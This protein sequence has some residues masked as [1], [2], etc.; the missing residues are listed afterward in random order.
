MMYESNEPTI[1]QIKLVVLNE[2]STVDIT[3]QKELPI[4]Y[5]RILKRVNAYYYNMDVTVEIVGTNVLIRKTI[6]QDHINTA[7]VCADRYVGKSIIIGD[8]P[9]RLK[10]MGKMLEVMSRERTYSKDLKV[11][12]EIIEFLRGKELDLDVRNSTIIDQLC[13]KGLID[14][15]F[16]SNTMLSKVII[17][18]NRI[19]YNFYEFMDALNLYVIIES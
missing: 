14:L 8:K 18:E 11:R 15:E 16:W 5:K 6:P 7:I 12:D 17:R 2:E 3:G 13:D 10:K 1:K 19:E 4:V 9:I